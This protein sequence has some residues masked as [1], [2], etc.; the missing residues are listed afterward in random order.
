MSHKL[1]HSRGKPDVE[2]YYLIR[3]PPLCG[4]DYRTGRAGSGLVLWCKR[5]VMLTMTGKPRD[6]RRELE[7]LREKARGAFG[8]AEKW[9]SV[10][11]PEEVNGAGWW[12]DDSVATRSGSLEELVPGIEVEF[13]RGNFYRVLEKA[14]NIWREMAGLP[15]EYVEV[16]SGPLPV[17]RDGIERLSILEENLPEKICFLDLETTGLDMT[18]LFLVGLMYMSDE[19]I[20]VDQLFA[21]DYTEEDTVLGFVKYLLGSFNVVITYNGS[22]F[23]IPF[24]RHRMQYHG[25]GFGH[26]YHH[27]DLL[28][29]ARKILKGR[30][31]NH[32]LQ[33]LESS[34]L[35]K[36]R[37]GDIHASRIP[38]VYHDFVRTGN[39]GGIERI[40]HHNRIDLATMMQLVLIFLE[41]RF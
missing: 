35:G 1:F 10:S 30:V 20:M 28:P 33:T 41:G 7:G 37:V 6:I 21:R 32:K 3:Y 31:P 19:D 2:M 12:G 14:E 4:V 5:G 13:R 36:K 18:P 8:V 16:I 15:R 9:K 17:Q 24:L 29:V 40:I 22:S 25:I 26:S 11:M 23:D 38:G 34:L 39:A 27:L